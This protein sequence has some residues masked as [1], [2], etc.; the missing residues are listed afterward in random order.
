[1]SAS[2]N[3]LRIDC[4]QGSDCASHH[5]QEW[6]DRQRSG[7]SVLFGCSP[8]TQH[9]CR[10][11]GRYGSH[12]HESPYCCTV[13]HSRL[14]P[15]GYNAP[16]N[17]QNYAIYLDTRIRAYRD[18]KHDAIRVQSESNRDMR[19]SAAIEEDKQHDQQERSRRFGRRRARDSDEANG[20]MSGPTRSKTIAGRKLRVMTVEKGLLRETKIVQ[21]MI[22][23]LVETRVRPLLILDVHQA[24]LRYTI[25]SSTLTT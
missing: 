22:D 20:S 8:V 6:G 4:L 10:S 3:T 9:H 18:L 16:Q 15:S 17:L 14:I 23:A 13:A 5:D 25:A 24:N 2:L 11:L 21:K 12:P 1:M 19:N 7:I